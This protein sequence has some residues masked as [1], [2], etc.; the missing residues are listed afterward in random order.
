MSDKKVI[1]SSILLFH[2]LF[3][4]LDDG[5]GIGR[6]IQSVCMLF[7]ALL[8]FGKISILKWNRFAKFNVLIYAYIVTILITSFLAKDID[9]TYLSQFYLEGGLEYKASSYTLGIFISIAF[10]LMTVFCEYVNSIGK[11]KLVLNTFFK[12]SLFYC[13]ISDVAFLVGFQLNSEGFIIGN[14]F[15]LSYLH[16]LCA[17]LYWTKALLY[18]GKKKY[19]YGLIL[20]AAAGSFVLTCTTAVL[21]CLVI[22]GCYT[23]QSFFYKKVIYKKKVVALVL[24]L[25]CTILIFFSSILGNEYVKF[26]IVDV[27]G[28]DPTLTGRTGIYELLGFVLPLRPWWGWGVGNAHSIMAYFFGAANAQNGMLNLVLEQGIIG[29]IFFLLLLFKSIAMQSKNPLKPYSYPILSLVFS[30]IILSCVEVT[31]DYTLISYLLFLT[32]L[33]K[34]VSSRQ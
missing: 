22:L 8:I 3:V 18:G 16:M 10:L 32:M 4:Y 30:F 27:L 15:T 29:C 26:V 1:Y 25:C 14:K 7:F 11:E 13:F 31:L 34:P 6:K 12:L 24:F 19:V 2:T 28:E 33:Y 17:V 20:L 9:I 5:S 21:G 23:C